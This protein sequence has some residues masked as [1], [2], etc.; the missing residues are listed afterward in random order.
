MIKRMMRTISCICT[1]ALLIWVIS[2]T[3]TIA[4]AENE[5]GHMDMET[6]QDEQEEGSD[7]A[8]LTTVRI[9]TDDPEIEAAENMS[10]RNNV[11]GEQKK[12]E[13]EEEEARPGKAEDPT[14]QEEEGHGGTEAND[15]TDEMIHDEIS[16]ETETSGTA[17]MTEDKFY[18]L[19]FLTLQEGGEVIKT[20][21]VEAGTVCAEAEG[22]IP[23][24]DVMGSY[25]GIG[26]Q[27]R[28]KGS[29]KIVG[30]VYKMPE[31]DLAVYVYQ[32]SEAKNWVKEEKD[33]KITWTY[34][35][36]DPDIVIESD[37]HN[38]DLG[39]VTKEP[40]CTE[41]GTKLYTC[42]DEGCSETR[43]ETIPANGH[44]EQK[45]A[46]KPAGCTEDGYTGETVCSV[47]GI[48]IAERRS[49][50]A[51]GHSYSGVSRVCTTCGEESYSLN[52][53]ANS[54]SYK[55]G[56]NNSISPL[57]VN[58]GE[59]T[60]VPD[61]LMVSLKLNT[62]SRNLDSGEILLVK[63]TDYIV[64]PL[65]GGYYWDVAL[66]PARL[67]TLKAGEYNV[68][69]QW[70]LN[71][72]PKTAEGTLTVLPAEE[73]GPKNPGSDNPTPPGSD[74]NNPGGDNPTPPGSNGNN[75][76]TEGSDGSSSNNAPAEIKVESIAS[77]GSN[78]PKTGDETNIIPWLI[79][80]AV[81]GIGFIIVCALGR[82]HRIK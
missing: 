68:I 15:Q 11:S 80:A 81:S 82:K 78:A 24:K 32:A 42:T 77:I 56:S 45:A 46:D 6:M 19:T 74:G 9:D 17:I 21:Q 75:P 48:T 38:W 18:N 49:I 72:D 35:A 57:R 61:D 70:D 12:A 62:V 44:T 53:G 8:V 71:N 60:S 20:I 27:W 79:L 25:T 73:E 52:K 63:G 58:L 69:I 10:D 51:T 55:L 30:S 65:S 29:G 66:R 28:V 7:A 13:D 22:F 31:E 54:T 47:C 59:K 3:G 33:G 5:E 34:S 23:S 37:S 1:I 76:S 40:T 64:N 36:S 2:V 67:E 4:S 16:V 50:E 26:Y 39:T 41:T 14:E 43:T